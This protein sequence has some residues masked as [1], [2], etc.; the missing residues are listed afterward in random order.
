[1]PEEVR[2]VLSFHP[3][4]TLSE[5]LKIALVPVEQA[6]PEPLEEMAGAA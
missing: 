6:A 2:S 4:E 3:V 5:V 1:V